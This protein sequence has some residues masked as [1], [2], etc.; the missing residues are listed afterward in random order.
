MTPD[1]TVELDA[2][3]TGFGGRYVYHL[4]IERGFINWTIVHLEMVNILITIRL[5]TFLWASKKIL[6]RCDNEPPVPITY[7]MFPPWQT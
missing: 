1:L 6:I 5:F 2:C 7:G 3:L 4:P